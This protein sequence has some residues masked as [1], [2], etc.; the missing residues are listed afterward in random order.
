M[1]GIEWTGGWEDGVSTAGRIVLVILLAF[2]ANFLLR[3]AISRMVSGVRAATRELDNRAPGALIRADSLQRSEARAQ[4][5]NSVLRSIASGTVFFFAV[6]IILGELDVDL[7]PLIAGA[8]VASIAIG[9]GAQSIVRDVLAG[10][11]VLLEDQYGVGDTIDT[12]LA[13]GQVEAFTLRATHLR[14]QAGTV[15][16]V[17]NG[18]IV[19]VGNKSQNWARAVIDVT[20]PSDSDVRHAR[21]VMVAAVRQLASEEAWAARIAGEPDDQGVQAM[22]WQGVTLR[23]VLDTQPAAQWKVERE[24]RLRVKEAF[25]REGLALAVVGLPQQPP[26]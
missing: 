19:Q 10:V 22:T 3:R 15:W 6:L 16:H 5:L 14:D 26:A 21:E 17:P 2:L 7:A 8:G 1:F 18:A 23:V 20:V 9:F 25:D 11:F 4:T 12:G 24:L 13:A